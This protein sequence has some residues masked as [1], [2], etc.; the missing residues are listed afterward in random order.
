MAQ[1]EFGEWMG[2]VVGQP[3]FRIHPVFV[4]FSEETHMESGFLHPRMICVPQVVSPTGLCR[5][6]GPQCAHP[7]V[8]GLHEHCTAVPAPDTHGGR[9]GSRHRFSTRTGPRE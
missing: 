5:G 3:V 4:I 2:K 1:E 7:R 9:E 8:S 6:K